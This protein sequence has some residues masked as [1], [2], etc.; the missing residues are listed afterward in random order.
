MLVLCILAGTSLLSAQWTG[1]PHLQIYTGYEP[2]S[3]DAKKVRHVTGGELDYSPIKSVLELS[4]KEVTHSVP[5]GLRIGAAIFDEEVPVRFNADLYGSI[6]LFAPTFYSARFGLSI[7]PEW[8]KKGQVVAP[9]LGLGL[10]GH[11]VWGDAGEVGSD[12]PNDL[13]LLAP[14][15]HSYPSGSDFN[16]TSNVLFGLQGYIGLRFYTGVH[17]NIFVMAGYQIAANPEIWTYRIVDANAS[18]V[19][20]EIPRRYIDA[21][22]ELKPNTVKQDGPFIRL[23]Y[24]FTP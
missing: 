2:F 19:S 5:I 21:H 22:P 17:N 10:E 16:L 11:I 8:K 20:Y 12:N 13:N 7:E 14:D 23:G 4:Q 9:F 15:G 24:S 6:H 1:H 3:M 18:D